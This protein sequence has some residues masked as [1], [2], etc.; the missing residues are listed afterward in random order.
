MGREI[1]LLK[2]DLGEISL[3]I[4]V[5]ARARRIGLRVDPRIGGAELV[6]PKGVSK[7]SGLKFAHSKWEWLWDH[8]AAMPQPI[9]FVEGAEV[10]VFGIPLII[11][12]MG[13][14]RSVFG[15]VWREND[16]LCVTGDPKHMSRRIHDWIK[17]QARLE[18]VERCDRR[19]RELGVT[20]EGITL[21]DPRS[22][23]GSCSV[24]ATLSFSWRLVMAPENVLDYVVAHE[25]A[26]LREM[27][28][29]NKFWKLVDQMIP[30]SDTPKAWL[31]L[32]G[33][34]LHRFGATSPVES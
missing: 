20:V 24:D 33:S 21:R 18:I 14:G 10:P 1:A 22:R 16:A 34:G 28:H 13:R 3:N 4:R 5:S 32:H 17:Q 8:V 12:H 11:S 23:W 2:T 25:V 29:S 31:R 30:D 26:H 19:S 9:P 27:N 7:N 15:P 6:L